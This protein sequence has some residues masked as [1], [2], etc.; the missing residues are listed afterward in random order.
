LKSFVS[1]YALTIKHLNG[2]LTDVLYNASVYKDDKGEVLGVLLRL[3][4]LLH[5]SYSLIIQL[6]EASRDPLVT[7][8][9]EGKITDMNEA[10]SQDYWCGARASPV[11]TF[12]YFTEP[13]MKY[14]RRY[15]QKDLLL[16][17]HLLF[18]TRRKIDRCSF[19]GS[20]Y[21]DDQGNVLGIVIVAE[22]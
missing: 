11:L 6:I 15:S 21:K 14:I 2:K 13:Q 1:D 10:T 18:V 3:E 20:V 5:K 9:I 16:I 7:I 17:H 12:D 4:M 19:N 8:S 22:I